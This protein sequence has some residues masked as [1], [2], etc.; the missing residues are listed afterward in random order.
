M[1]PLGPT[2]R[3]RQLGAELRRLRNSVDITMEHVAAVLDCAR[4]RIGHI[5]NGR[6]AIRKPE[7]KVVLDLYGASDEEHQTLEELRQQASKRGWS[8]TYRLPS[9]LKRYVE[10]ETDAA[11]VR[12]FESEIIP[13]LLQTEEYARR[14]HVV[15][16]HLINP[17]ELERFVAARKRRQLRLTDDEAPLEF[18][19]VI[20]E[21]AFRR[22]LGDTEIGPAQLAHIVE[23]ARRPN[24]T[25]HVLP[26]AAG[27]HPS[28]SGS[29]TVLTFDAG[30]AQPFGYQEHAV[31]GH[32]VDDQKVIRRLVELWELLRNQALSAVESLDWLSALSGKKRG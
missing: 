22:A 7:L 5:E 18:S 21:A 11:T 8:S 27:L 12:T 17:D 26:Y 4:S 19:T 10:M 23:L 6:N 20:S 30:V 9:W 3:R 15:G 24:V 1:P 32:L 13:G 16:A 28:M 14:V 2:M 25:L 29:F 31:D